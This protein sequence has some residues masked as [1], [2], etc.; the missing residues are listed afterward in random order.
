[1]ANIV[2]C[3]MSNVTW[4]RKPYVDSFVEGLIRAL[5]RAGNNILNIR[6]NDFLYG[7]ISV[8]SKSRMRNKINE[9]RPDLILT[10]N[11]VLPYPTMLDDIDCPVACLAAD[12]Y[13]FFSNKDV[14]KK[15]AERYYFFNFSGDTL[16]TL[17]DWFPYVDSSSNRNILF[18]HASDMRAENIEQD[19][20]VSFVG[21]M[22]N[23]NKEFVS[24]FQRISQ[25]GDLG[26]KECNFIKDRFFEHITRFKENPYLQLSKDELKYFNLPHFPFEVSM[27]HLL[28]CQK[29]FDVLSELTDL[30]LKVY[31]YPHAYSDVLLYSQNIFEC[32]DF[33]P[34]VTLSHNTKTYNRSKV[35]LNLPHAHA[36][37]GF[38][39]RVCDILASNAVLLSCPQPD[40]LKL[41][42]GYV[43][44]PTYE[45]PAEARDL[46]IKLLNDPMWRKDLV[47]G[48]QQMID[49]NCRFEPKFKLIQDA[50]PGVNMFGDKAGNVEWIDGLSLKYNN[51][52]KL[53]TLK[54]IN[55]TRNILIMVLNREISIYHGFKF[56]MKSFVNLYKAF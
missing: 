54:G 24:F 13:A 29:R 9:F 53:N 28:T 26:P 30:G 7:G 5:T 19:I 44:L 21:S 22:G 12:S 15:Y 48:S 18:G 52:I 6:A 50:I 16:N 32:F 33:E 41:S 20:P 27:I 17:K 56:F 45:S 25:D 3:A 2:I 35:S 8:V 39:W 1:M 40:L 11:N 55:Q 14:I 46:V 38:S 37:E 42:K 23:W 31:G 4:L 10:L 47:L 49:D 36:K 51:K 43:D 34:S